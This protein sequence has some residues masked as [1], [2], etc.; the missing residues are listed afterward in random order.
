MD[1]EAVLAY[2]SRPEIQEALLEG[3]KDR[4]VVG[5]F[6]RGEFD[7]RPNTLIYPQDIL[8]Q[9]KRGAVEFHS[10]VERWTNPLTIKDRSGF[11]L[12]L[13]LDCTT[14][15]HGK[16]AALTLCTV[17]EDHGI[18]STSIKFT[19]GSGFHL[20]IP[21]ESLPQEIGLKPT[22]SLFPDIA[23]HVA[24]YIREQMRAP[25]AHALLGNETP[26]E[27]AQ[28]V[29]K[30]LA[31]IETKDSIDPFQ[32]VDIDSVLLSPRHLYRMAY[33]LNRKTFLASIPLTRE[34]LESFDLK[35]AQPSLIKPKHTFLS[36]GKEGEA[37]LLF[38]KGLDWYAR[39]EKE[40]KPSRRRISFRKVPES[41]FPPCVKNIKAGL[42]EGRKRSLFALI[43]F[44][45]TMKWTW[46]EI[47]LFLKD[48]NQRNIPPLPVQTITSSLRYY[49]DKKTFP[50]PNCSQ[51]GWFQDFGVCK[52]DRVCVAPENIKNPV[53]YPFRLQR[54]KYKS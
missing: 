44:L 15:G 2:Y 42:K 20:G 47:E 10:S 54:R 48:W 51:K 12:I 19:G 37:N 46:D 7:Q 8:T 17:L 11:D 41:H 43:R 4:E 27:L 33:S 13:D 1:K 53:N 40:K 24:S 28:A 31:K 29:E 30:P 21:W 39:Q 14:T 9:V 50:P 25:L 26:Q 23:R 45:S 18:S 3:A 32:V 52:P 5:V 34:E 35:R 36:H 49:R 6:R 16:Q 22:A 38:T